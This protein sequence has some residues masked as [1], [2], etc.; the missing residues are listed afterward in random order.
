MWDT[1]NLP[2]SF[3]GSEI[4]KAAGVRSSCDALTLENDLIHERVNCSFKS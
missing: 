1:N 3:R 2:S 4:E